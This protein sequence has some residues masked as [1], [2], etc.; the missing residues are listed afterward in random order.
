MLFSA[1]I[2]IVGKVVLL[3]MF[4]KRFQ[5]HSSDSNENQ[6]VN[7]KYV[8]AIAIIV[9]LVLI[10]SVAKSLIN[11]N[12]SGEFFAASLASIFVIFTGLLILLNQVGLSSKLFGY[13]V[14]ENGVFLFG[15]FIAH[16]PIIFELLIIFDLVFLVFLV[17]GLSLSSQK[18]NPSMSLPGLFRKG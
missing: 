10:G 16:V 1:A 9:G 5:A 3:P 18:S 14:I 13:L 12:L 11:L 17:L 4:F 8:I 7:W 15:L 6:H 2:I